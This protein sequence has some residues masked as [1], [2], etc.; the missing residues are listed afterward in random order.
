M[1]DVPV[2]AAARFKG[3]VSQEYR[4]FAW[5]RQRIQI[6][7]AD[8]ILG[9]GGICVSQAEYIFSFKLVHFAFLPSYIQ[10]CLS[11]VF[12]IKLSLLRTLLQM[13]IP[14]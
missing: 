14:L 12:I 5:I 8:E 1:V 11:A 10:N 3:D 9:I 4:A 13:K 7:I 6:R 2:V